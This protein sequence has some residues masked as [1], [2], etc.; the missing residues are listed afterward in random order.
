[1][2]TLEILVMLTMCSKSKLAPIAYNV[3]HDVYLYT[4]ISQIARYAIEE[5]NEIPVNILPV[6]ICKRNSTTNYDY[7]HA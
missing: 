5:G 4:S 6:V 7:K 2:G 3:Q 1:M